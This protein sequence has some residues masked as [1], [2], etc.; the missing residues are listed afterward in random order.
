[1]EDYKHKGTARIT[2]RGIVFMN[3]YYSCGRA[4]REQ[5]YETAAFNGSRAV[6]VRFN[7]VDL[8]T[9]LIML[10]KE[11]VELAT[12]LTRKETS[13]SKLEKY[14]E[15]IQKLKVLRN[16]IRKEQSH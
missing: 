14:F 4:I 8:T 11:E 15:S 1:M 6:E 3:L 9:I 7:S 5:W 2:S 13:G 10:G 16:Q 12:V